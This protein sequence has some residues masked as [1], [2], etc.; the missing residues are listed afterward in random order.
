MWPGPGVVTAWRRAC[1]GAVQPGGDVADDDVADRR[2]VG[3]LRIVCL[4]G[5]GCRRWFIPEDQSLSCLAL[6]LAHAVD[7]FLVRDRWEVPI[8]GRVVV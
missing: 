7:E 8:E 1:R 3:V 2:A 5:S 6:E 4:R